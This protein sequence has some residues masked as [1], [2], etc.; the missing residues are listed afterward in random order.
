MSK[1]RNSPLVFDPEKFLAADAKKKAKFE[2]TVEAAVAASIIVLASDYKEKL[3]AHFEKDQPE[4]SSEI[5][6]P[7]KHA[8]ILCSGAEFLR[9]SLAKEKVKVPGA[10]FGM[11]HS[12]FVDGMFKRH[13]WRTLPG[14]SAW[15]HPP[16]PPQ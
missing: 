3:Y 5:L 10:I 15:S 16:K 2:I 6:D 9:R 14:S 13:G 11:L 1:R 7:K 8:V 4:L 12:D